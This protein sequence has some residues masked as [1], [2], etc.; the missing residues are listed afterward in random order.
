MMNV[1]EALADALVGIRS[2]S[3]SPLNLEIG[4]ENKAKKAEMVQTPDDKYM[5]MYNPE[6]WSEKA[7]ERGSRVQQL[8]E[9][10][11]ANADKLLLQ[12]LERNRKIDRGLKA[13]ESMMRAFE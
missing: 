2:A 7:T 6:E 5:L 11:Q 8:F 10:R 13:M 4:L 3:R 9:M 1:D 12:Q